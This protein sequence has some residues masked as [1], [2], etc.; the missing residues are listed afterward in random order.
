MLSPAGAGILEAAVVGSTSFSL[1][2]S[3]DTFAR[4]RFRRMVP[5]RVYTHSIARWQRLQAGSTRLHEIC[6]DGE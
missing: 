5:V 3:F 4:F 2:V 6:T 1:G